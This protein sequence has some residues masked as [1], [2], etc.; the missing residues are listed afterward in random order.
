M[1]SDPVPDVVGTATIGMIGP[2]GSRLEELERATGK[3][4]S[5]VALEDVPRERCEFVKHG[6][7]SEVLEDAI[8][9]EAGQELEVAIAEPHMYQAADAVAVLEGGYRLVVAGAGPYLGETHKVKVERVGRLEAHAVL[10]VGEASAGAVG[11]GGRDGVEAL[12][13]EHLLYEVDGPGDV[14]AEARHAHLHRVL[15]VHVEVEAGEEGGDLAF[16]EMVAQGARHVVRAELDHGHFRGIRVCIDQAPDD[17][18]ARVLGEQPTHA[19]VRERGEFRIDPALEATRCL[20]V[21]VEAAAHLHDGG[22][23]PGRDLDQHAARGL[24]HL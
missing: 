3:H 7:V 5:I 12:E 11:Q 24:A 18:A 21:E 13:P 22:R 20:R 17:R 16:F 15:A 6:K 23:I 14:R 2:G 1:T 4:F 10:L 8:P 19:V 9:V